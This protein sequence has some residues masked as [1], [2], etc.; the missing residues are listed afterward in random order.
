MMSSEKEIG[1]DRV[2]RGG[3]WFNFA[4]GTRAAFRFLYGPRYRYFILGFR[5]VR[6]VQNKK[7]LEQWREE[8]EEGLFDE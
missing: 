2:I 8:A 3:S 4:W 5:L 7:Q 6:S 1:S